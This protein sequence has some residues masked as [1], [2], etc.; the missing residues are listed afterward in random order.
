MLKHNLPEKEYDRREKHKN[1]PRPERVNNCT[2]ERVMNQLEAGNL[3]LR[4][5]VVERIT[6]IEFRMNDGGRNG[7]RWNHT[8]AR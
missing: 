5:I 1:F 7:A 4:Y 8:V 6:V 3:R 2:G